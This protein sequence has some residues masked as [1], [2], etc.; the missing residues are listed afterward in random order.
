[1]DGDLVI[2]RDYP[3]LASHQLRDLPPEATTIVLL[4]LGPNVLLD[5]PNATPLRCSF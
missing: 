4:R 1:V 3:Q 5:R 2:Q